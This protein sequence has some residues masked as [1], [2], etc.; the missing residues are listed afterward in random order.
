MKRLT[1]SL[2]NLMI[3]GPIA[4]FAMT[5][6]LLGATGG[7]LAAGMEATSARGLAAAKESRTAKIARAM[8]AAPPSVSQSA[9]IVDLDGTVLRAG[10]NGWTCQPG[11]FPGDDHPM[12][13]DDV[14]LRLVKAV[15]SKSGFKTDRIGISYMLK[16]DT[17]VSNSNPYATDPN[18]GDVWI[19]EG[20]HLMIVLPDRKM[21]EGMSSNPYSGG[22]YVM[23]KDTPYA[24][25]MV[26]VA[27]R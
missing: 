25:I 12:C 27:P 20:P 7:A 14:W 3:L 11:V 4:A 22:P 26:P 16:G 19:E 2:G 18:N 15:G 10:S 9:T 24:H 1:Q 8:Q 6:I 21:L 13:N 23:W 17:N 5:C